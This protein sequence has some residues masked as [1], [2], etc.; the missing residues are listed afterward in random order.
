MR[1][2]FGVGIKRYTTLA[3]A[4]VELIELWFGVGI[5]RYTTEMQHKATILSCGLV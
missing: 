4:T 1:L 5:K 2:W 3:G